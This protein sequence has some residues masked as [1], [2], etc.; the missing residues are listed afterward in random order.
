MEGLCGRRK[1]RREGG[2]RACP[3]DCWVLIRQR[4]GVPQPPF[5]AYMRERRTPVE[6]TR[7]RPYHSDDN[8]HVE[9]KNW[10]VGTATSG[11]RASGRSGIG[12]PHQ[13]PHREAPW[14]NFFLP[15]L[16]LDKKWREGSHWRK[17]YEPPRTACERLCAPGMLPLKARRQLRERRDSLD[18]FQLKDEL[19]A[20]LKLIML[21]KTPHAASPQAPGIRPQGARAK[22]RRLAPCSRFISLTDTQKHINT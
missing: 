5:M 17:R 11:L 15:C 14:Q 4:R 16:K 1:R 8:A 18:P 19:E 6:F 12:G 10:D 13:R 22:A 3:L 20:K 7:S 9:Q 2:G 21:P